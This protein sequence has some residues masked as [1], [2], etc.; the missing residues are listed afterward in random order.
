MKKIGRLAEGERA[1]L[2]NPGSAG[3]IRARKGA[4]SS[5]ER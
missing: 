4:L 2:N 1:D 3:M 5:V